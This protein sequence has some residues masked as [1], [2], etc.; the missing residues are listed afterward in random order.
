MLGDGLSREEIAKRLVRLHNVEQLHEAQRFKIWHLRDE[1]RALKK[2]VALLTATVA[3]QQKTIDDLKLQMEE[4]RTIV[5]GK[6][7]EKEKNHD[8]FPPPPAVSSGSRSKE[9]YRR[10]PPR[11]EDITKSEHHPVSQCSHCGESLM[12]IEMKTYYEEDIPLP[13]KKIIT[14]HTVQKGYCEACQSWTSGIT[15]PS[16]PV[17]LGPNVRRYAVYL[18][19]VCRESYSQIEDILKQ[20]YEFDI[21][22]GEI[23]KIMEKEGVRLRPEYERLK[24][25]IRGEPSIHLDETGWDIFMNHGE[26]GFAWTMVGGVSGDAVFALGKNRGKGNA[27]DLVGD[28]E[29]VIVRDGYT[30]YDHLLN[31]QQ[32]CFAHPHRKLRDLAGSREIDAMIRAHCRAAY[33]TFAAIY[34]GV[35]DALISPDRA[36]HY[37]AF[38][39]S[40]TQFAEPDPQDPAK[41]LRVKAQIRKNPGQYLTCITHQGVAADNNAA[42]RSLRHLVIKRKISFGSLSERTAETMAI[43]CSVLLSY[44][45]RGTLRSYLAGV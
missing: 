29:A 36:L 3:A 44:R 23:A 34:A 33:E 37:D 16:A 4:M 21:S 24:A 9:S 41:L 38:L 31:E 39:K 43:L 26:R 35:R 8:D 7:R 28:S 42:E 19:V 27:D 2:E 40:L 25:S 45:T 1:N 20:S 32:L 5:F 15:I 10:K 6:K 22:Q 11:E 30:A 13:Q 17:I 18:S 14:K 12:G